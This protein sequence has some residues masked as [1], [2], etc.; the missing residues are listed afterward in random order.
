MRYGFIGCGNMGGALA[1]AAAKVL[2]DGDTLHL[3]DHDRAKAENLAA[4]LGAVV[5]D[6]GIIAEVCDF[7]ILG[8]KPQM[9]R[10]LLETLRPILAKRGKKPVLV[11]MAAGVTLETLNE[12]LGVAC[13]WVRIMP[14][15]PVRVGEGTI[16]YTAPGAAPEQ[17]EA[18]LALFAKAGQLIEL[19]ERLIDAGS[20]VSG[21]GPAFAYL[22]IEALADGGVACGL[23]RDTALRLAA[24]TLSGSGRMVLETG[25]HPGALKDAVCSPAGSTIAGVA[26]LE[27]GAFRA[28]AF[29]AVV[30]AFERTKELGKQ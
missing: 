20:A 26:A 4:A 27:R 22:F 13:P 2:K 8:V 28:A 10:A 19:E 11:S 24:S 16:L 18:F 29:D 6:N 23:P 5:Q 21:C 15:T 1:I 17:K 7:I 3:A 9:M 14:N 30:S 25:E 12:M